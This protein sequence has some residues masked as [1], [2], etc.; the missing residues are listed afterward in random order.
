MTDF[1]FSDKSPAQPQIAVVEFR[2]S[3]REINSNNVQSNNLAYVAAVAAKRGLPVVFADL[4]GAEMLELLNRRNPGRNFTDDDLLR[5]WTAGGPSTKKGEYNLF[6]HEL[7]MYG[8]DPFMIKNI[9]A[10][11][12]RYDVV[13]AAFGESHYRSHRLILEDM[14]GKPEYITAVPNVRGNFDDIKIEP[15]KLI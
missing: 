13:L 14:L 8:R 15:V 2:N 9:T 3:G 11:L 6:A 7:D 10:A 5:V 4:S 12:N 1:C